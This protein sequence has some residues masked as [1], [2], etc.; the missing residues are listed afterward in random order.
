MQKKAVEQNFRNH[1]IQ[2]TIGQMDS[3]SVLIRQR[4]IHGIQLRKLHFLW[5]VM[6]LNNPNNTRPSVLDSLY[7]L[8]GVDI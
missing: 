7:K 8:K 5:N 4:I 6:I 1:T 3:H 2:M